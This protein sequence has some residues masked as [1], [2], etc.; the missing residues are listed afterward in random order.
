MEETKREEKLSRLAFWSI[1]CG[2]ILVGA[3]IS[4][5]ALSVPADAAQNAYRYPPYAPGYSFPNQTCNSGLYHQV[6][7]V[8]SDST[9]QARLYSKSASNNWVGAK[10]EHNLNPPQSNPSITIT[11]PNYVAVKFT[12]SASGKFYLNDGGGNALALLKVGG[13]TTVLRQADQT[14]IKDTNFFVEYNGLSL[15]DGEY[16]IPYTNFNKSLNKNN[17]PGKYGVGTYFE[18]RTY[19]STAPNVVAI[20]TL[21]AYTDSKAYKVTSARLAVECSACP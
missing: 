19:G 2:S 9:G 3:A 20:G 17:N 21:D 16:V 13:W 15:A 6:C 7:A 18:A 10:I 12:N 4:M 5:A 11:T 8:R 1:L 14:W